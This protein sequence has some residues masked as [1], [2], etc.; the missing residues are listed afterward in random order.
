MDFVPPDHCLEGLRQALMC[1]ADMSVY[2]LEWTS[3]SKVKPTVR[4]PQPHACVD[5]P[6]LHEWMKGR[7][8][9]IEDLEPPPPELYDDKPR[10]QGH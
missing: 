9:R 10:A 6:G 5:W 7:S 3:H 8:A 4:V 1:Q 2:T